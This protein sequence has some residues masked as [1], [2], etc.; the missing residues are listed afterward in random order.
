M[1]LVVLECTVRVKQWY[2]DVGPPVRSLYII[3]YINIIYYRHYPMSRGL[4]SR[5]LSHYPMSG[6][7]YDPYILLEEE[8]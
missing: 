2:I 6:S 3:S 4:P 5:G 1:Y 7:V 8:R